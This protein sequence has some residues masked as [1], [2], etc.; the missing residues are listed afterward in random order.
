MDRRAGE[1]E[2]MGDG[3]LA[4]DQTLENLTG[5]GALPW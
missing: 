1:A 2:L 3:R 5:V 4:I